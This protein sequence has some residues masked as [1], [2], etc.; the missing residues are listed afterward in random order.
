MKEMP[1][2]FLAGGAALAMALILTPIMRSVA[3]L[4]GQV[5][6]PKEDR[7]HRKETAMLGG[8]AIFISTAATWTAAAWIFDWRQFALPHL[9]MVV[10]GAAMFLLGLA[11]DIMGMDPQHKL[12]GQI[13]ISAV[14]LFFGYSLGWS[15]YHTADLFLSLLWLVGITNAFNLLD[16]MDGLSAGVAAVAAVFLGFHLFY[17][18]GEDAAPLFLLCV[19]Y[20]GALLGFLVFNFNPASIFMGDAGS[21]FIGFM[22]ACQTMAGTRV[23]GQAGDSV[24]LL[25]VVAIPV[26]ILFIPI[27]DTGFVSLMRRLFGRPISKGGR[28]HSSHRMVAIGF[29]EKKA[30]LVMYLFAALSGLVTIAI[31]G[32]STWTSLAL[33]AFYLLGVLF[34][35]IYLGKVR[36]YQEPS[37]ISE[38]GIVSLV[39]VEITYKRRILEVIL[40]LFLVAVSYYTA[41]LL[42]FEGNLGGNFDFFLKS[43]PVVIACQILC[44]YI[45]GVYRGVWNTTG[46]R[47]LLGY[48]KAVSAGTVSAM[49]IPLFLYRFESFSRAVF[50]IYWVIMIVLVSLSRLSFRLLDEGIRKGRRSGSPSL[51]YGAGIGGQMALKEIETNKDLDLNIIGFLDDDVRLHGKSLRGYEVLGG[52]DSL[53]AIVSR[54][55]IRDI[56]VAFKDRGDEKVKEIKELFARSGKDV[57]VRRMRLVIE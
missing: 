22:L 10:C 57:R 46:T 28:D 26:L 42:R 32:L 48:I 44:M 34:F 6:V 13:I 17:Y 49:L 56:I 41:Y 39:L 50:V 43:L 8:V 52:M 23:L 20:L 4:T 30:V 31:R 36:V 19:V 45:F 12:A 11:D 53:E 18:A 21:L 1:F 38:K 40:D 51:I 35:W 3:R 16:N 5:A 54:H 15:S 9:V 29:S 55:G 2:I 24:H 33:T 7:W 47:D 25:S 14:V 27:L 37:L